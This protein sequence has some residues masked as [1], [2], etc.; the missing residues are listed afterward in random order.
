MKK[1]ISLL[2]V[3][4]LIM[5]FSNIYAGI[6]GES[7]PEVLEDM[8]KN[9]SHYVRIGT[10]NF[11]LSYYLDKT[12]INVHEYAPPNYIISFKTVYHH[13]DS[14]SKKEDAGYSTENMTRY[15]YDYTTRKMYVEKFDSNQNSYWKY[16]DVSPLSSEQQR[17]MSG[18]DFRNRSR[19][20]AGGE[21]AF[22]LAYNIRFYDEPI[23]AEDFI[24]YGRSRMIPLAKLNLSDTNDGTTHTSHEYN[25][26]TNQIEVWQHKYNKLTKSFDSKRIQ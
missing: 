17:R 22:Y 1:S 6:F 19:E 12:T 4:I 3:G 26:K 18:Q 8:Y 15:K 24:K 20:I 9:P 7:R 10:E 16:V 23:I 14:R 11:G 13:I 2:L 25:H 21:I 5:Y